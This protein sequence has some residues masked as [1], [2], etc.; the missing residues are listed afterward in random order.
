MLLCY[1]FKYKINYEPICITISCRECQVKENFVTTLMSP[2]LA[3]GITFDAILTKFNKWRLY[4][5][6]GFPFMK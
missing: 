3:T 1:T 2:F 4:V 6:Y 5:K